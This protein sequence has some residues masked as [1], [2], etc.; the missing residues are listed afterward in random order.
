[1]HSSISLR[2]QIISDGFLY[3]YFLLYPETF[4]YTLLRKSSEKVKVSVS[5]SYRSVTETNQCFS[6]KTN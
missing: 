6:F 1:M 2:L 5:V 3:I 4:Q